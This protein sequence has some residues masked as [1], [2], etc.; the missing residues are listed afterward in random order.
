MS[1]QIEKAAADVAEQPAIPGTDM[2]EFARRLADDV[3]A[4]RRRER[5]DA[6]LE[7]EAVLVRGINYRLSYWPNAVVFF[8]GQRVPINRKELE[9]LQ[10]TAFDRVTYN[11]IGPDG[12]GRVRKHVPKFRYYNRKSSDEVQ[13]EVPEDQQLAALPADPFE[14]AQRRRAMQNAV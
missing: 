12:V 3:P 6:P 5:G 9:H 10:Q 8:H 1:D 2:D 13:F 11:D 4:N 14:A 7:Y